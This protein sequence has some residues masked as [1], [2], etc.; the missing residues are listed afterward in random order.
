MV[1]GSEVWKC[2]NSQASALKLILLG[3]AKKT[4]LG[5]EMGQLEGTWD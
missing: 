3:E 5:L 2:N 1:G 4:C